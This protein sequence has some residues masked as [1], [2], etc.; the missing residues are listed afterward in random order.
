M[1]VNGES[2]NTFYDRVINA[3]QVFDNNMLPDG[4]N[5]FVI[6]DTRNYTHKLIFFRNTDGTVKCEYHA[7][8][9]IV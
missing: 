9:K 7:L 4:E 1:Y 3:G 5:A 2:F 6:K 8:V